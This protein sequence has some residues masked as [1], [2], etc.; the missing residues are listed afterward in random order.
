MWTGRNFICRQ[1]VREYFFVFIFIFWLHAIIF[2]MMIFNIYCT[3]HSEYNDMTVFFH[4]LLYLYKYIFSSINTFTMEHRRN[5]KN[6]KIICILGW[7]CRMTSETWVWEGDASTCWNLLLITR[8]DYIRTFIYEWMNEEL[9]IDTTKN[10]DFVQNWFC[11]GIC[12]HFL[13]CL[14]HTWF[15]YIRDDVY[16]FN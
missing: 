9:K 11:F 3:S 13:I 2:I 5:T 10:K 4:Y 15:F 7:Q 8:I 16:I 1:W 6:R 12:F 14:L